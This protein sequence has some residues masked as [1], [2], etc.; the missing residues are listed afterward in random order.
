MIFRQ[1][2]S[3]WHEE[4]SIMSN[5]V[6]FG[7]L[8]AIIAV[9]V[10]DGA[11]VL[12]ANRAVN[13][14]TMIAATKASE[15]WGLYGNLTRAQNVALDYCEEYGLEA[16]EVRQVRELSPDAFSVTCAKDAQTYVFKYLPVLKDII[17]QEET[18]VY[19]SSL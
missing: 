3:F 4:G 5:V 8:I 2:H 12:Q 14:S 10:L 15:E 16:V 18:S 1:R 6:F 13:D 7:I 19:Y 17:H 11:S 9:A